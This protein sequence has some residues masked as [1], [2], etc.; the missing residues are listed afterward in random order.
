MHAIEKAFKSGI[1]PGFETRGRRHQKLKTGIPVTPQKGTRISS[2]IFKNKL[3]FQIPSIQIPESLRAFPR[4]IRSPAPNGEELYHLK[5]N[6]HEDLV[7]VFKAYSECIELSLRRQEV[8]IHKVSDTAT[9]E[10]A[11]DKEQ[12]HA[13]IGLLGSKESQVAL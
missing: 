6:G 1:Y 13:G 7:F 4:P 10:N 5:Q 3:R 2:N 8:R 12:R 11:A 9:L